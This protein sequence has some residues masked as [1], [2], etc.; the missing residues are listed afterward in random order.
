[1]SN[2]PSDEHPLECDPE[3]PFGCGFV[4]DC[5]FHGNTRA[6]MRMHRETA[7]AEKYNRY[8]LQARDSGNLMLWWRKG[9]HGYTTDI[10]QAHIFTKEEAFAQARVRPS[11][12]FPWRKYYI[13]QH[14]INVVNSQHVNRTDAEA[15]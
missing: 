8:Y 7:H 3:G 2:I 14:L 4:D 11:E 6:E 15:T 10:D 1:M 13:D 9:R 12:D 5:I